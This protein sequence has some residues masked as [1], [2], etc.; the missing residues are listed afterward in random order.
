MAAFALPPRATP[1]AADGTFRVAVPGIGSIDPAITFGGDLNYLDPVCALL[2]RGK[3][4]P[5]VATAPP[6][7]SRDR[8]TYTFRLRR[9]FRFNTGT[10][11]NAYNFAHEIDRILAPAMVTAGSPATYFSDIVGANEVM[12]GK[13]THAVGVQVG[14]GGYIL[15]FHLVRPVPD[16]P[17]RL[18]LPQT[19]PVATGLPAT[20]GAV[21]TFISGSGPYYIAS[22]VPGKSLVLRRNR[23]YGGSRLHR[24]N[25][26]V[27]TVVGDDQTALLAVAQGTADWADVGDPSS[28]TTLPKAQRTGIRVLRS[29]ALGMRYLAMNTARPLFKDNPR[30]RRAVN[31]A[32]DRPALVQAHGGS[33]VGRPADHY[34]PPAFPGS[35]AVRIYPLHHPDVRRAA[36]LARGHLRSRTAV[37]Y[38]QS[39]GPTAI[40]AKIVRRDLGRVGLKVR[41]R[42]FPGEQL[43]KRLFNLREHYD[44]AFEGWFPD[45]VD[46]Y[47]FLNILVGG[48]ALN[49]EFS[50]N[51]ARFDSPHFNPLLRRAEG[52]S[53]R[54]RFRA[55]GKIDVE[56]VR[57]AAPYATYMSVGNLAFVSKR[58]GCLA[59]D[60]VDLTSVCLS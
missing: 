42:Y 20:P 50:F 10:Q 1:S 44:L 15:K 55:Y 12:K 22:Y 4:T 16:F 56:V 23:Y 2:L 6:T 54:P 28:F 3:G 39:T 43:F 25:Q 11:V 45:W 34:L 8:R 21:T 53:G 52:L 5:E 35:R 41:I 9:T 46:P 60:Q 48:R 31:F 14:G 51:F 37:L 33:L 18:T 49:P 13:A 17:A 27:V 19:C 58:V 24:S 47:Q 30:L 38:A 29:P 7:L 32:L 40:A 36:A 59:H 26:V 57:D